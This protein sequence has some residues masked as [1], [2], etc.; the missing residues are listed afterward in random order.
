MPI[1]AYEWQSSVLSST[2]HH[3]Y[4]LLVKFLYYVSRDSEKRC[5]GFVENDFSRI[6]IYYLASRV[7]RSRI[8][9][10]FCNLGAGLGPESQ[11]SDSG[12]LCLVD[13]SGATYQLKCMPML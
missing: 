11:K 4:H 13:T 9:V 10:G 12:H 2:P 8:G 1:T 6:D 3:C 5:S 7:N